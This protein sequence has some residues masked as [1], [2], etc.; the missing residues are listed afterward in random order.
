MGD[1]NKKRERTTAKRLFTRSVNSFEKAIAESNNEASLSNRFD[2]LKVR[3][4][5]VQETHESFVNT[6]DGEA[7]IETEDM[8]I[9]GLIDRFEN[10]ES[11]YFRALQD[12]QQ[13]E[14]DMKASAMELKRESEVIQRMNDNVVKVE[15]LKLSRKIEEVAFQG[16]LHN[17]CE[18]TSKEINDTNPFATIECLFQDLKTLYERCNT[19]NVNLIDYVEERGLTLNG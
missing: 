15:T 11:S 1:D 14:D 5:N 2:D 6:V 4:N 19:A 16:L 9:E 10:L 18:I 3:W 12:I 8:W 17:F 7:S 13:N